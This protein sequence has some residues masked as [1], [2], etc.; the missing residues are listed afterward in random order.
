M[1]KVTQ[2]ISNAFMQG[3]EI[4]VGNTSVRKSDDKKSMIMYLHGNLIAI[5]SLKDNRIDITSA[6]WMT[7]VTK[8]RLN[9]IPNVSISQ[10]KGI[11]Y[12]NGKEW[13]GLS[14]KIK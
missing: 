10:R 7:N 14:I 13:N 12:L 6:G 2:I 8:E 1:R 4:K 5:R 9:G 11:W 3:N